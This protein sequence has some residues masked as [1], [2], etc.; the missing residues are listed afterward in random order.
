MA[1]GVGRPLPDGRARRSACG[2]S[3]SGT[4]PATPAT[5]AR[6]R[7]SGWPAG[8]SLTLAVY[9]IGHV[10]LVWLAGRAWVDRRQHLDL[11]LWLVSALIGVAIGQHFFGHYYLQVLPPLAALAATQID[12][13]P[14]RRALQVAVGRHRRVAA[15]SAS[16][17]PDPT[18]R[19][20]CGWWPRST[21][22][23]TATTRSSCGACSPRPPGRRP[24]RWPAGS[25]TR[26]S[27]PAS[28]RA[29]RR[30]ARSR[31]CARTSRPEPRR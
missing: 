23:P 18:C 8:P 16:S 3:C 9:A 14:W 20:T 12:R 29:G 1:A 24:G 26:T 31:T 10:V 17:C 11:W 7:C 22:C 5:S 6:R 4:S 28:T 19:P 27:S 21:G 30:R 13:V 2:S 25:P 15:A